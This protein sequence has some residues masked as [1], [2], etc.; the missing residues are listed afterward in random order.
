MCGICGIF[1]PGAEAPVDRLLVERMCGQIVHRG[2]DEQGIHC[3]PGLG[4]GM[5][6]L[7]IIDLNTGSQP[8]FNEDHSICTVHNGE[9]YNFDQLRQQLQAQGHQFATASDTEVVVHLYEQYGIDFVNHL[10]G[11]FATAVWDAK[12]RRLV[13][14]RDRMGQK[15]LYYCKTPQGVVFGSELKCLLASGRVPVRLNREAVCHF[16]TL[17]YIP[18]PLTIY[19]NVWQ[20]P[21]GGR[22]VI[23][24]KQLRQDQY[25]TIPTDVDH[26]VNEHEAAERLTELLTD[27]VRMRMV[28]DVPLGA[29]LSGGLDSS[30]IVALM[31]Q[32]SA[33]PVKTFHIDFG[34]PSLSEQR[35]ARAVSQR[36]GTDHHELVVEASAAAILD[37]LVDHFDEPFGDA[38]AIPTYYVSQLTRQHVTVA[39][40]GDGGD[41]S[42]GGYNRYREIMARPAWGSAVRAGAGAVGAA[43][44]RLLPRSAP[45]RRYFRSLGM[46]AHEFFAVG[47]AELETRELLHP[48]FI[49]GIPQGVT[50]ARLRSPLAGADQSDPLAPFSALDLHHYLPDDILTKVDRMSMAHSLELRA[51]LLDYRIIEF[52]ASLPHT[53]KIRDGQTKYLLK[54]AFANRLPPEVLEQRKRGFSPPVQEWLRNELRDDLEAALHD[55]DIE[56]AGI[57]QLDEMRSLAEEH[58]S[59]RRGR[60]SQLWRYLFFARWWHRHRN[61]LISDQSTTDRPAHALR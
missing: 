13:L 57:F 16:F 38:S 8:V 1:D 22:L 54:Q 32:Q 39:L 35:Y 41:E 26:R 9:I 15:P 21:P 56:A 50:Y 3:A 2:P 40:A 51:P 17:G 20:L 46:G 33:T 5:R 31:A 49:A 55:P 47:T 43:V 18:N 34:D 27:A 44:H 12:R 10:N 14:V 42:F 36:Y 25:W 48:D 6:R 60:R 4:L 30:I 61:Q 23:E 19:E 53:M 45:G 58:F 37:Q 7:S 11:M 29:F 24:G 59:R 52:A 28:S